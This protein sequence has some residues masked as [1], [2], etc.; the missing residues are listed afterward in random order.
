MKIYVN[1]LSHAGLKDEHTVLLFDDASGSTAHDSFGAFS[2]PVHTANDARALAQC[3]KARAGE[4]VKI[5]YV[6]NGW[7]V[8]GHIEEG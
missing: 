4:A 1:Q 3:I 8:S 2:V 5:R 7:L 6:K